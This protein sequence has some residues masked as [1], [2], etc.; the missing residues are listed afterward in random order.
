MKWVLHIPNI[1]PALLLSICFVLNPA[2]LGAPTSAQ[3]FVDRAKVIAAEADSIIVEA[4]KNERP[5]KREGLR[6]RAESGKD[7]IKNELDPLFVTALSE[8]LEQFESPSGAYLQKLKD[9]V[10][11]D[12]AKIRGT[13]DEKNTPLVEH[14]TINL[15]QAD[16][17]L[18]P[19]IQSYLRLGQTEPVELLLKICQA[20]VSLPV[21]Y[22]AYSHV[23]Y[24]ATHANEPNL[25]WDA[26]LLAFQDFEY[27]MSFVR[28]F[29]PDLPDYSFGQISN[30]KYEK[31]VIQP[32]LDS[33]ASGKGK[34]PPEPEA[35]LTSTLQGFGK[36]V[37]NIEFYRMLFFP[38]Q[39]A[40]GIL[41]HLTI[42][43]LSKKGAGECVSLA[44][45]NSTQ[46]G[47]GCF[48]PAYF[49]K[50]MD[51]YQNYYQRV[52]DFG[53][54]EI[55]QSYII[56]YLKGEYGDLAEDA[57]S[58]YHTLK[59]NIVGL[60]L[61]NA[62]PQLKEKWPK[63][64][65]ALF[66]E[67]ALKKMLGGDKSGLEIFV[68]LKNTLLTNG[69]GVRE[70][71]NRLVESGFHTDF[72]ADMTAISALQFA[73]KTNV[74]EP[75]MEKSKLPEDPKVLERYETKIA[76]IEKSSPKGFPIGFSEKLRLKE[77]AVL[78]QLESKLVK[79]AAIDPW[80]PFF[81]DATK[82]RDQKIMESPWVIHT[83]TMAHDKKPTVT[84]GANGIQKVV[85]FYKSSFANAYSI[86]NAEAPEK[87]FAGIAVRMSLGMII[88]N[89]VQ[90]RLLMAD[91]MGEDN[92]TTSRDYD[93]E[94]TGED[95]E[96]L[97]SFADKRYKFYPHSVLIGLSHEAFEGMIHRFGMRK[98]RQGLADQ[99]ITDQDEVARLAAVYEETFSYAK[100]RNQFAKQFRLEMKGA[101]EVATKWTKQIDD[102][103]KNGFT[104]GAPTLLDDLLPNASP[105]MKQ[106][107]KAAL[108]PGAGNGLNRSSAQWI[109]IFRRTAEVSDRPEWKGKLDSDSHR[110]IYQIAL[111]LPESTRE[112]TRDEFREQFRRYAKS[113][114][115]GAIWA[116]LMGYGNEAEGFRPEQLMNIYELASNN[117]HRRLEYME[118][119]RDLVLFRFPALKLKDVYKTYDGSE[120]QYRQV[121]K[122]YLANA[123]QE[124]TKWQ[125]LG[126]LSYWDHGKEYLWP[127]GDDLRQANKIIDEAIPNL[128]LMEMILRTYPDQKAFICGQQLKRQL[129]QEWWDKWFMGPGRAGGATVAFVGS[130]GM[131]LAVPCAPA[132]VAVGAGVVAVVAVVSTFRALARAYEVDAAR[133]WQNATSGQMGFFEDA[134][135][136][137]YIRE[138]QKRADEA[139]WVAA[140]DVA[141]TALSVAPLAPNIGRFA[142]T[143]G[144][145]AYAAGPIGSFKF[146][147]RMPLRLFSRSV[148]VANTAAQPAI[149]AG[150][151]AEQ[152]ETFLARLW[153]AIVMPVTDAAGP[154]S[155]VEKSAHMGAWA[156]TEYNN[157]LFTWAG[158]RLANTW[159]A[160]GVALTWDVTTLTPIGMLIFNSIQESATAAAMDRVRED[161]ENNLDLIQYVNGGYIRH[162]ELR[163]VMEMDAKLI[164]KLSKSYASQIKNA[165]KFL[166]SSD[167]DTQSGADYVAALKQYEP[168]LKEKVDA[169]K[170]KGD[171]SSFDYI[172]T[173]RR[174]DEAK[175]LMKGIQA[176]G[177]Q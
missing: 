3:R 70:E 155:L 4:M 81:N 139:F 34:L 17:R 106:Q 154:S 82:T 61:G 67:D 113:E 93:L 16:E 22:L 151:L 51:R 74:L 157:A 112:L 21:S 137:D 153:N 48:A 57:G 120:T 96:T 163:G 126:S 54:V 156:L 170:A 35:R 40:D 38:R 18:R 85:Q 39:A 75:L 135:N 159:R 88:P 56:D 118:Y 37:G 52:S 27:A 176:S 149:R 11:A 147:V 136:L 49:R 116:T 7:A 76:S 5:D 115:G 41:R 73:F 128:P 101:A 14:G 110:S 24:T 79:F 72:S 107:M 138:S 1:A 129:S 133:N 100:A 95:K 30:Q 174:Y 28:A 169:F 123:V 20:Y 13:S 160:T 63:V 84:E 142:V 86:Q 134:R 105:E 25:P 94:E 60:G 171:K 132:T 26:Y 148:A 33:F 97:M 8:T 50:G 32:F 78:E 111:K 152:S 44:N 103:K 10:K 104:T 66:A 19:I 69:V 168:K 43:L 150:I 83:E 98:F 99:K 177:I 162:S 143:V 117:Y 42:S 46:D 87:M 109:S 45:G 31:Q 131:I 144:R 161:R 89:I 158:L 146:V 122:A 121:M 166:D 165:K 130:V 53:A 47:G 15:E 102:L 80:C 9:E 164:D 59:E 91:F 119:G 173:K 145:G 108:G 77:D 62:V 12:I 125:K 65:E 127:V 68:F 58:A 71:M 55:L 114:V 175:W 167:K 64:L 23:E 36:T 2:A 172:I 90:A 29:F 6:L 92:G 124:A 140:G 141:L